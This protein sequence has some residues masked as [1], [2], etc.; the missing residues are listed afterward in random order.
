VL[1]PSLVEELETIL[2]Q[3]QEI[4]VVPPSPHAAVPLAENK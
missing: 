2:S 4:A 3:Q 1:E